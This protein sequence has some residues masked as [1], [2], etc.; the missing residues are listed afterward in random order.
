[1]FGAVLMRPARPS[2]TL[3]D[4][5]RAAI[6]LAGM[7]A[8]LNLYAPQAVLPL[9]ATEFGT[10]PAAISLIMTVS[11]FA[12][13]LTAP[14]TG[15]IADVLGRKGVIAS[16]L[17]MLV[18]PDVMIALAPSLEALIAWRFM[19]GLLLPPIFAVSV[20]YIGGEW[21]P[22]EATGIAGFFTAMTAVGGFLGRLLT[23]L[24]AEPIGW[25]GAF[26]ANA[27]LTAICAIAVILLLPREKQFV[28]A[29]S[30][31]ASLKQML[32]H[33]RNPL[34][35]GTYAVGFG[36]L[37]SFMAAF[38]YVNFLLAA[39]PFNLSPAALGLI[40]VVYLVGAV[41]T[42]WTGR[43]VGHFGRRNFVIAMIGLWAVGMVLTLGAVAAGSSSRGSRSPPAPAFSARPVRKATSRSPPKAALRP[44]SA[45]MSPSIISAAPSAACCRG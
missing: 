32:R 9:L 8:M 19:Q 13:A 31:S 36:V 21:P 7:G 42:P 24:L 44:P 4:T 20:A 37:F 41:T 39:P 18:I 5:R 27:A 45:F 22:A 6:A 26:L 40:F 12:I 33:F 25:R 35:L 10:S 38:T 17:V 3:R 2:S 14:F 28:R 15:V 11:A 34:L 29:E 30:L 16:A 43:L 1:M 23:G